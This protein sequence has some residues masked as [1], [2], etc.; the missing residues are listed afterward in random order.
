ME[1]VTQAALFS[2]VRAAMLIVGT[3]AAALGHHVADETLS[4]VAGALTVMIAFGWGIWDKYQAERA[5]KAREVVAVN[6]GKVVADATPGPTP[7]ST[8][9]QA[10]VLIEQIAPSMPEVVQPTK[11]LP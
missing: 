7:L 11:E 3:I 2:A 6:V 5:T 10:A 8:P 9:A 4:E 1:P